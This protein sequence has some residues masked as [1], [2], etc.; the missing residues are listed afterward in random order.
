MPIRLNLLAEDQAQEQLRRRDPT[1]RAIWVA[2][3]AV[4]LVLAWSSS[5][6]LKAMLGKIE[7]SRL[8]AQLQSKTNNYASVLQQQQRL[9]L[10]QN[11]VAALVQMATNKFMHAT[12]LD[13]LQKVAN[14]NI[15]LLRVR[16]SQNLD[17]RETGKQK[18][19]RLVE[20]TTLTLEARDVSP[21]PGDQVTVY[22]KG[23]GALPYFK[24]RLIKTNGVRLTSLGARTVG[25]D[26]RASVAF[27]VECRYPEKTR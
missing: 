21:N 1:K 13:Q 12:V 14:D 27:A 10:A 20:T 26:G 22:A 2:A 24:D 9:T 4:V 8:Q 16:S 23:L 19:V 7:V 15:E 5:L 6:Q 25:T 17:R 18:S 3:G 11:R